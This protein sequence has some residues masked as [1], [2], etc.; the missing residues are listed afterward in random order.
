MS[1]ESFEEISQQIGIPQEL[2]A[3]TASLIPY[4]ETFSWVVNVTTP[5]EFWKRVDSLLIPISFQIHQAAAQAKPHRIRFPESA[6]NPTIE[7]FWYS[8][9]ISIGASPF[10]PK[11]RFIGKTTPEMINKILSQVEGWELIEEN[12]NI[13]GIKFEMDQLCNACDAYFQGGKSWLF[14]PLREIR[15]AYITFNDLLETIEDK[16][17]AVCKNAYN[18][19]NNLE[20]TNKKMIVKKFSTY[21]GDD[22]NELPSFE[23]SKAIHAG[24]IEMLQLVADELANTSLPPEI[25]PP[26]QWEATIADALADQMHTAVGR[27]ASY[28]ISTATVFGRMGFEGEAFEE[29]SLP[30]M[31]YTNGPGDIMPLAYS[32]V[33]SEIPSETPSRFV[34]RASLNFVNQFLADAGFAGSHDAASLV[35]SDI[36]Q[37]ELRFIAQTVHSKEKDPVTA[38][39]E[40]LGCF[41]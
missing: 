25:H 3:L 21:F 11:E 8:H 24:F 32:G 39:K 19:M 9:Q 22:L 23:M 33:Y 26:T 30:D 27:R 2:V 6:L 28:Q 40:V 34:Q 10:T 5:E 1:E 16:Y 29:Y 35:L 41:E 31:M 17:T 20:Y 38:I 12:W 13:D 15:I 14:Y 18:S 4:E 37:H 36:I 7:E